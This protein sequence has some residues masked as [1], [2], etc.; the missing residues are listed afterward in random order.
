MK[1]SENIKNFRTFRGITQSQ[2]ADM[3]GKSKNTI[4][5]WERGDNFPDPD[6]I[7]KLCQI[8]GV[9]PNH[10]FGWEVFPEL[11]AYLESKRNNEARLKELQKKQAELKKEMIALEKEIARRKDK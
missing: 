7:E 6:I 5:N 10:L 8:F 4:S 11:E 9:E 1:L 3:V 2:L